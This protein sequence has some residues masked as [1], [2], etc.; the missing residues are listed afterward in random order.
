VELAVERAFQID[1]RCDLPPPDGRTIDW[2]P[3]AGVPVEAP[4]REG[5]AQ[6][7]ARPGTHFQESIEG[8]AHPRGVD[9]TIALDYEE[10]VVTEPSPSAVDVH[11]Q[12]HQVRSPEGKA[13][14]P[15]ARHEHARRDRLV[16]PGS[17]DY[18]LGLASPAGHVGRQRAEGRD[19]L[20]PEVLV[21]HPE[22]ELG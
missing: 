11:R 8:A 5:P 22:S 6:A 16:A 10:R 18:W 17:R 9:R 19:V 21:G 15:P 3:S 12:Q 2:P 1:R 4:P 13:T 14:T 20:G 7:R